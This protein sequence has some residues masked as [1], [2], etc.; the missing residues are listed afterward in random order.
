M[1]DPRNIIFVCSF[2]GFSASGCS[3]YMFFRKGDTREGLLALAIGS[4]F[5]GQLLTA[6]AA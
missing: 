6:R 4:F 1:L 5:L 2:L 3:A